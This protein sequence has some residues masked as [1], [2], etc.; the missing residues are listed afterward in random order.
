MAYLKQDDKHL[1]E[2]IITRKEFYWTKKWPINKSNQFSQIIPRFL[3]EDSI[4]RSGNL[5]LTSY[6]RFIQNYIHPNSPY[7]RM[8][9][10]WQT[11]T[12]KSIG[13]LS[14]AMNFIEFY[15]KEK[16]IGH[17]EIGSVFIIGF[18][19]RVFKNELLRFPEF[20]FLT[21]EERM[22]LDKLKRL[23]S[24]GSKTDVDRYHDMV[25]K[26]K[27]RFS[28]RKGNGFFKFFGYKAF[29][30]RIFKAKSDIDLQNM[31]EEQIRV[32][33]NKGEI[34]F[35]ND[36]LKQFNHSLII[37]DEIHNVYNSLEKNNWGIAIQSVLDAIPTCR[38]V[39]ASATPLNNNPM[40]IIDLLNLLLPSDQR[41]NKNDF[42]DRNS[43]LKPGALDK[44]AELS[45]GRISY[46]RDVNPKYYPSIKMNGESLKQI[47]YLKFIRCVMSPFHY[48]TYKA[49]YNGTLSQD[50]QYLVDFALEN[51]DPDSKIGIYQTNV[52]K[53]ALTGVS[54]K[55]YE[56]YGLTYKN[57]KITG[58][59][60]IKKNLVKYSTKYVKMLDELENIINQKRGKVFIYHNIVH[61]SGVLFIE[62]VL[63]KNGYID[64]FSGASDNTI[65][66]RCG[67]TRKQ[68][69]KTEI[70]GSSED[71]D[72]VL[73]YTMKTNKN[74]IEWLYKNNRM[75]TFIKNKNNY[76]VEAGSI[77]NDLIKGKSRALK[78]FS[79]IIS[80]LENI[81]IQIEVPAYAPRFGEW[82]LH[83]GFKIKK[84]IGKKTI[85][86]LPSEKYGGKEK[87]KNQVTKNQ[88]TKKYLK[89]SDEKHQYT[90]A[91][92]ILAH[93]DV[94]KSQMEHSIEKFNISDNSDGNRYMIL[95]GSKVMKESYDIK[96]IQNVFIM[97]RPDNIPT[98]LQIRGRAIRK[99][100]HKD[101]PIDKRQVNIYIFTSCLPV[102]QTSG[103]DKGKYQLSYEE[104]KYKD[105]AES[106]RVMQ[107]IEKVLHENAVDA[108]L[109]K[110]M[111]QKEAP[112]EIDP[113]E[114]LPFHPNI[115]NKYLKKMSIDQLNTIT[116][117]MYY[118]YKEIT[119]IKSMIKRLFIEISPVWEYNDLLNAI[120][121][122]PFNYETELNT[123]LF[124]ESYFSIAL[125]QLCWNDNQKYIEPLVTKS[126]EED[127]VELYGGKY[128]KNI[129]LFDSYVGGSDNENIEK[130][131]YP[132]YLVD[133]IY[134]NNDKIIT[135]PGDQDSV[136]IP[137]SDNK[138]Q[139]YILFPI[140]INVGEPNIDL[141][142]PYR[143]VKQEVNNIINMNNFIQTK[144]LDFDYDD[145]KKIFYRKYLDISI[146]NMENVV[147]EYG[148]SFHIKFLE[149]CI[150]YVFR[151]WTDPNAEKHQYHE[152]YFKM[153]YY[154]DLLSLVMWAYTS[155]P[156]VFKNYTKYAIP[157]KAKD[158]KLK[159]L[160]KYE[161][162]KEELEDISPED[163]SDLATS[164]VINL[165]KSSINRTSN[166]WVP[167]EF[168]EQFD[169]TLEES[170]SLYNG[171]RKKNKYINK[172]SAELLPIGHYISKF[173]K[174]FHPEEGWSE[175]PTYVQNNQKFIENNIIIGFNEKSKTGVH[176]R[177]KIRKPIHNIKKHK[178][179]RLIE[180]GSVCRSSSKPHLRSIANKLD[181]TI[182]D[183]INVEELCMLIKAKLIRLELKER[184]K[185]S[186]IKYFY[187][188]YEQAEYIN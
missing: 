178:D 133:K 31:S 45:R 68:H 183:K 27:R 50:S 64:E 109:N 111:I 14:I 10:K 71:L 36:L 144:R 152:F 48:E 86:V 132:N 155:K 69:S 103:P 61:M 72:D 51:P 136:I 138:T 65:C 43:N 135:L 171:K 139:Y 180:K 83:M 165:L 143:V 35:D 5:R 70:Y 3:L 30:N 96:A 89:H 153:L 154:Y 160:S 156:R 76:Y 77:H 145:K 91:R 93:S 47:P 44:I 11:G 13:A 186:N 184:I 117:D 29:V 142:L 90:P 56:K 62:E 59:G 16:E 57:N 12:G 22:K 141:D 52:I 120:Q 162:R 94:D 146:E 102:K 79:D 75:I 7:Q 41:L 26:I 123:E 151:S 24:V 150:E 188:H 113:L 78:G 99:N 147:C 177:F 58:D 176:V 174:I 100:S 167:R 115:D 163:D 49:V 114:A 124:T 17:T 20:G 169:K 181:I 98:L 126:I 108:V 185:K 148:T 175:D 161:K 172:V 39:Y 157:V 127:K 73:E 85:M 67:K 25:T 159:V 38:A 122:D 37:C 53:N 110:D 8:L 118:S 2:D 129:E 55:W 15:R 80:H 4:A 131:I 187:Q 97:G 134:D 1:V 82:L 81:E 63:R 116:F 149:E 173:P 107:N 6:Q 130:T 19:E 101:L 42:F 166:V 95:I 33:L 121:T 9:M 54:R 60:L 106:F 105:K 28:N 128:T 182:P 21:K 74:K 112:G 84:H 137:M 40:E 164:G 119:A 140:D 170:Y 125:E 92:F 158:I 87:T 34:E 168:R 32:A 88:V 179:T 23:A 66:M 46:L 18:S 104:E